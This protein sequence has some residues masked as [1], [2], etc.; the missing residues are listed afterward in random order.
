[1]NM[2]SGDKKTNPIYEGD[3]AK[4]CVD[5]I[6]ETNIEIEAGGKHIYTRKQLLDIIQQEVAPRHKVRS[7]PMGVIKT[8]L[9]MVKLFNRNMY[10]KLAFFTTVMQVDTI[11]PQLGTLSF[12]SYIRMSVGKSLPVGDSA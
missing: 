4:I 2:G 1:M 5:A 8:F 9:P 6:R 12:E 10:D 7:V 3:L 11:A